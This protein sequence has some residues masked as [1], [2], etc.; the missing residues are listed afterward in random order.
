MM[1]VVAVP[2]RNFVIKYYFLSFVVAFHVYLTIQIGSTSNLATIVLAL[3]VAILVSLPRRSSKPRSPMIENFK[4]S[5]HYTTAFLAIS[6][7]KHFAASLSIAEALVSLALFF[8]PA[9]IIE[10]ILFA[11]D[12]MLAKPL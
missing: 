7:L 4:I 11:L 5:V 8:T 6:G 9:L 12:R 3:A 2:K 10:T 1:E